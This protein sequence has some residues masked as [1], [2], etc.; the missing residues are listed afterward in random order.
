MIDCSRNFVPKVKTVE[1][2]LRYLA[3]IG[4]NIYMLYMEDLYKVFNLWLNFIKKVQKEPFFGYLRG[5]ININIL[6][7]C[8]YWRWTKIDR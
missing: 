7:R 5:N 1:K 8:L 4:Y 3:L 2:I 6:S